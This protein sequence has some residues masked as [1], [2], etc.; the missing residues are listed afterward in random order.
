M[1]VVRQ[2]WHAYVCIYYVVRE[3]WAFS[4]TRPSQGFWGTREKGYLFQGNRGTKAKFWGEQGNKDNIGEQGTEENK[5]SIFGEQGNKPIYFKGTREQ[6]PPVR[7]LLTANWPTDRLA[8]TCGSCNLHQHV[9]K[10]ICVP[11]AWDLL[12]KLA[13]FSSWTHAVC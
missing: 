9:H 6:V 12:E 13:L 11:K 7:A 5:F 1:P 2:C 10:K 8:H 4:L 3:L